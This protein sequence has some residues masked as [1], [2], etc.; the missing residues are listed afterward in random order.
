MDVHLTMGATVEG[1]CNTS[2]TTTRHKICGQLQK[3][4]LYYHLKSLL[5]TKVVFLTK[6][7]IIIVQNYLLCI[8]A[9][10]HPGLGCEIYELK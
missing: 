2:L 9:Y 7:N 1:A 4:N 10:S 5:T 6:N 3:N 8:L